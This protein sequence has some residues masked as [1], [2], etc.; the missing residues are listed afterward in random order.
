[1]R[2]NNFEMSPMR[3]NNFEMYFATVVGLLDGLLFTLHNSLW[4][5]PNPFKG[6]VVEHW[7]L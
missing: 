3:S 2:N 6:V 5:C 4:G 1:M 7:V